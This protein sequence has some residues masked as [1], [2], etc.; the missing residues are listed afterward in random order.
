MAPTATF[1]NGFTC[2]PD[3]VNHDLSVSLD[4]S[5]AF[6]GP[7]KLLEIWFAPD[8]QS[9]PCGSSANGLRSVPLAEVENLLDLVN[10]KVLSKISTDE[11]DAYVLSESSLFVYPHKIVLKT[12][13]TTTTLLC[14]AKLLELA[15]EYI[16]WPGD[17]KSIH[18]I[19]YSRRC[20]M[21]PSRQN[22]IHQSWDNE[23]AFLNKFFHKKSSKAYIVGDMSHDHWYLYLNGTEEGMAAN[24]GSSYL[25]SPVN[26]INSAEAACLKSGDCDETF[27]LLMTELD[28]KQCENF[29]MANHLNEFPTMDPA[30]EDYGHL[31]GQKT[32]AKTKLD[33]LFGNAEAKHDAFAF[34]P[35]GFSSNSIVDEKY[36]YTFHVTPE[37]GWSYASFETNV[38][39][40]NK[41]KLMNSVLDVFKPGKFCLVFFREDEQNAVK[42]KVSDF[43]LL[44]NCKIAGYNRV[45]KIAYDLK[46]NYRCLYSYFERA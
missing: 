38:P 40:R 14:L 9:L 39:G 20:F 26:S 22:E 19:F 17:F 36:Y 3:Y 35:C 6:E 7:E 28:Q 23:L 29:V 21:F 42:G 30:H 16:S 18:R 25:L 24:P 10:C 1:P 5:N 34:T 2:E 37:D 27:E 11:M 46:L 31:L 45:D 32:M 43:D 15:N 44:K 4:S 33:R 13:G 8:A 12:C 41:L